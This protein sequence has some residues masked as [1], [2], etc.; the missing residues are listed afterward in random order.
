M[1]TVAYGN[2]GSDL[3]HLR[4]ADHGVLVNGERRGAR[5]RSDCGVRL[6]ELELSAIRA[7]RAGVLQAVRCT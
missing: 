2:A 5:P 4:L 6:R 1:P 7:A 3:P